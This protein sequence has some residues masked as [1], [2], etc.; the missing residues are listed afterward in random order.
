M[1]YTS[2][3]IITHVDGHKKQYTFTVPIFG[4]YM[5]E[6]QKRG[7]SR[8]YANRYNFM[9]ALGILTADPDDENLMTYEDGIQYSDDIQALRTCANMEQLA[10]LFKL[11]YEKYATDKIGR[12]I[13]IK[14]KDKMKKELK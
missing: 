5:T 9:N 10:E 2:V 13:M 14:E 8:S 4:D 7:N 1:K 6:V 12:E 11:L 3:I